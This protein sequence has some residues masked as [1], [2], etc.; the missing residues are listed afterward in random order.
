M[1]DIKELP[2]EPATQPED[3]AEP[4][5]IQEFYAGIVAQLLEAIKNRTKDNP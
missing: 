1:I 5:G 3:S 2:D 4:E